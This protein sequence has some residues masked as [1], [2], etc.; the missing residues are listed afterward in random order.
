[1]FT[2][3]YDYRKAVL[4]DVRN[5]IAEEID[6]A[7]W[8]GRRNEL[9]EEL[10]DEL[11]T[12]DSVTGNASGSYWFN[13][14]KAEESLCHNLDL[15]EEACFCFGCHSE[16]YL[17]SPESADVT[18]RCY[19]L[20]ECIAE[21]LDEI[22]N[23]LEE[24]EDLEQWVI[25]SET[26]ETVQK[27]DLLDDW[28]GWKDDEALECFE[29]S[30]NEWY[31]NNLIL[32]DFLEVEEPDKEEEESPVD[33]WYS[34]EFECIYTLD[35]MYHAWQMYGCP[36]GNF[37]AWITNQ[38]KCGAVLPLQVGGKECYFDS[39]TGEVVKRD[40]LEE[41]RKRLA[42]EKSFEDFL[43]ETMDNWYIKIDPSTLEKYEPCTFKHL[44]FLNGSNPYICLSY[45][46]WKELNKKY[47]IKKLECTDNSYI[48]L[49]TWANIYHR[50]QRQ[51]PEACEVFGEVN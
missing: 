4:D 35:G 48:A 3:K 49:D 27:Q 23:D 33:L 22:E 24:V 40:D 45:R 50:K 11:W 13:T 6:T 37:R 10:N 44:E 21:A 42:P 12:D 20:G 38:E 39:E 41:E 7:E 19:L 9:E 5:Y 26:G 25:I 31:E 1:M 29:H 51:K 47:F 16:E 8:R 17:T 18:I 32:G 43:K 14:W 15:L 28:E 30:F 34:T 2:E 46:K 36:F